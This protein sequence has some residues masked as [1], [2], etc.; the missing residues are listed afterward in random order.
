MKRQTEGNKE[1][2]EEQGMT[3]CEVLVMKTIWES[4]EVLSLREVTEQVN[5]KFG[6]DWKTQTVSTF[7]ARLVRKGYLT[8]ERKGR[9]F[10]YYPTLTENE[11]GKREI[12]KCVDSWSGGRIEALLSAFSEERKL[13]EDEKESIRR[14]LDG[15]D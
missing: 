12:V 2:I 5:R 4:A 11:Y 1:K 3:D 15:R 6:R 8:M 14:L 10:Y 7:L 9:Q 13:T